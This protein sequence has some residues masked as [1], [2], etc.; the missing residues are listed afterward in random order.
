MIAP[1]SLNS[2]NVGTGVT[3]LNTDYG[4]AV[5]MTLFIEDGPEG[6]TFPSNVKFNE[7]PSFTDGTDIVNILSIDAGE[8]WLATMAG[9]GFGVSGES[10]TSLGSCCYLDGNCEEF[11]SEEY[12]ER[13]GGTFNLAQS[14]YFLARKV[15]WSGWISLPEPMYIRRSVCGCM[16]SWSCFMR[17]NNTSHV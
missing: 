13:S 4:D 17:R 5:S 2:I 9:S 14:W 3:G 6:I 1:F 11:K 10:K 12:C 15:M 16:L 8:S 7:P